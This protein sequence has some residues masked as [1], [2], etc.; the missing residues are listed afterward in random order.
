MYI[1]IPDITEMTDSELREFLE[2]FYGFNPVHD[3]KP[4]RDPKSKPETVYYT[5]DEYRAL[6]LPPEQQK[7]YVKVK[8]YGKPFYR[9][10]IFC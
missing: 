4:K 3:S 10:R 8:V 1:D 6:N 2:D 9:K 5:P 7:L